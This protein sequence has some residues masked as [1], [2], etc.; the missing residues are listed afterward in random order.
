[1]TTCDYCGKKIEPPYVYIYYESGETI[2]TPIEGKKNTCKEC[3]DKKAE[4]K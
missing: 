1:M 3:L 2:K 4:K